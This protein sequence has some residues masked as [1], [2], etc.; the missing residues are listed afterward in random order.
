MSDIGLLI[1][2]GNIASLLLARGITRRSEMAL[3]ALAIQPV[4]ALRQE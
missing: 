1:A 2:C 3:R 4:K